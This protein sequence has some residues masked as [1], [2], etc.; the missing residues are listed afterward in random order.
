MQSYEVKEE[1]RATAGANSALTTPPSLADTNSPPASETSA[2]TTISTASRN[3][4][5][6]K[7][8]GFASPPQFGYVFD[9]TP[10]QMSTNYSNFNLDETFQQK[11]AY[12]PLQLYLPEPCFQ[13]LRRKTGF[14][15][16]SGFY[17]SE[18]W[19]PGG[20]ADRGGDTAGDE[21]TAAESA[22][23]AVVP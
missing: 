13:Q 16:R 15:L 22:H 10:E 6:Q 4:Q 8:T 9:A 2:P 1:P 12:V 18:R 3:Q 7:Q 20:A 5:P 17:A 21:N 14:L 19:I 23:A 11:S